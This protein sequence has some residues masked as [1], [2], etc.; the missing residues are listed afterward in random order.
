MDLPLGKDVE[1]TD[2]NDSFDL[3]QDIERQTSE[4]IRKMRVHERLCIK[5]K[6]L[7]QSG[8][9]SE[10][11]DYKVQGV[12]GDISS[13]GCQAMFPEPGAHSGPQAPPDPQLCG[14]SVPR[15]GASWQVAGKGAGSAP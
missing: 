15:R 12:T 9:S 3:L 6:V 11:L 4:K 5:M 14:C 8:N 13:G 10:L 7:L 1:L 2:E